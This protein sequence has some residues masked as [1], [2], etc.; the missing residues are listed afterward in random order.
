[1][2]ESIQKYLKTSIIN[3]DITGLKQIFYFVRTSKQALI[4][5]DSY[6]SFD[7]MTSEKEFFTSNKIMSCTPLEYLL[8]ALDYTIEEKI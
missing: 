3:T 1:M 5:G 8:P 7:I 2:D 4:F 6:M